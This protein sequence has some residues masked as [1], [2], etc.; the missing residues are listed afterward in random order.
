M[1]TQ[2]YFW[3]IIVLTA[4][5][6]EQKESFE[7]QLRRRFANGWL[8]SSPTDFVVVADQP[9]GVKIGKK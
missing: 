6:N 4:I 3:D 7:I 8:Q 9:F 5:D 1:A 2:E